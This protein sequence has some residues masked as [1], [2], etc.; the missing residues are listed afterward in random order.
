LSG[1]CTLERRG[2]EASKPVTDA[3]H[4]VHDDRLR[5]I[6]GEL[7][8]L[9][10]ASWPQ[11]VEAEYSQAEQYRLAQALWEARELADSLARAALQIPQAAAHLSMSEADRRSFL[12][13]VTTLEEQ[14]VRLRRA[15]SL[16]D[17]QQMRRVLD[18]IDATCISCHDRFRDIAGPLAQ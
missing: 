9:S 17:Q 4:W 16:G 8:S 1:A 12:A 15:A 10:V 11:E 13:Q 6:M 14:A 2:R 18:T 7:E 5:V 3:R